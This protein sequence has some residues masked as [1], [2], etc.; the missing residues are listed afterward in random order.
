MA[1]FNKKCASYFPAILAL[2]VGLGLVAFVDLT[3]FD[4][5]GDFFEKTVHDFGDVASGLDLECGFPLT[6]TSRR[7]LFIEDVRVSCGC[8]SKNL[9]KRR[10][11]PGD[12]HVL[13]FVLRTAGMRPPQPL[14]KTIL[15]KVRDGEAR[16]T[17]PL[18]ILAKVEPDVVMSP[19]EVA[20][21]AAGTSDEVRVAIRRKQLNVE[22]FATLLVPSNTMG[23]DF[24]IVRRSSNVVELGIKKVPGRESRYLRRIEIPYRA[25]G[26]R[27]SAVLPVRTTAPLVQLQPSA[28]VTSFPQGKDEEEIRRMTS[29]EFQLV[30]A[31]GHIEVLKIEASVPAGGFRWHVSQKDPARFRVWVCGPSR[32]V[33]ITSTTLRISY[34]Y[35]SGS[36]SKHGVVPLHAHA[37]AMT[38]FEE[39]N[40]EPP[41]AVR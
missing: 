10:L 15:V 39:E 31:E 22:E 21:D 17:V 7:P 13:R 8:L 5:R 11:S 30:G 34:L 23:Y 40:N 2:G 38:G 27:K 19:P 6:N 41:L 9:S 18:T 29:E 16:H 33:G 12:T 1:C 26:Q 3:R 14:K 20:L 32:D 24:R 36:Q 4:Q 37:V 28:Y 25:R 35:S